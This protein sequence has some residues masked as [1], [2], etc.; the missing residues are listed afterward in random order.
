[1]LM[2]ANPSPLAEGVFYQALLFMG[3][4]IVLIAVLAHARLT[5]LSQP[6]RSTG[7]SGD[8]AVHSFRATLGYALGFLWLLDGVLQAQPLV[9]NHFVGGNLLPLLTGQPAPVRA[10][11]GL[12]IRIWTLSP[13]W[14]NATAVWLQVLIGL[15]L[16]FSR[17]E[18]RLRRWALRVSLAWALAIWIFGEGFGSMFAGGGPLVGSPG[19]ALLYALVA[20]LLLAK[21]SVI[22]RGRLARIVRFGFGSYFFLMAML[23]ALPSSGFWHGRV[24]GDSVLAMAE[25]PQPAWLAGALRA[26]GTVALAHPYAVTLGLV[27]TSALLGGL[28]LVPSASRRLWIPTFVWIFAVWALGQDFGVLGGMGTD[29]NS[30][31][32]LLIFVLLWARYGTS[33]ARPN[34]TNGDGFEGPEPGED[35]ASAGSARPGNREDS[36]AQPRTTGTLPLSGTGTAQRLRDMLPARSERND[37]RCT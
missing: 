29:P 10:L 11:L 36:A 30:G 15:I 9:A 28:W 7:P 22:T 18:T 20:W 34:E 19:A 12:G 21:P 33:L 3:A 13:I 35:A 25:M 16:L 26:A 2:P 37:A 24:L 23:Q 6:E 4:L 8:A 14:L 27:V 17:G 32:I 1:M 5:Q 31:G